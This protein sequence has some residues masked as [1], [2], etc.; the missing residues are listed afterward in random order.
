LSDLVADFP[1][2]SKTFGFRAVHGS[3]I[4]KAVVNRERA[5]EDRASFAGVIAD[6]EDDIELLVREFI[7]ML[8]TVPRNVDAEFAHHSDGFG[9]HTAGSDASAENV[10]VVAS[11]VAQKAFGHLAPSRVGGAKDQH[12][13]LLHP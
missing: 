4:G 2:G 5:R 8:G 9:P 7:D 10:E 1:E 13:S 11:I 3:W 6:R 12:A